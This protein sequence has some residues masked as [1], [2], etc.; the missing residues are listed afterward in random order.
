MVSALAHACNETQWTAHF[1]YLYM[2]EDGEASWG[3]RNL[4]QVL[5]FPPAMPAVHDD[6][7]PSNEPHYCRHDV[8][9]LFHEVAGI[10]KIC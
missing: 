5:G 1:D 10:I 7:A 9:T 2:A 3:Q 6:S 4:V 8:H